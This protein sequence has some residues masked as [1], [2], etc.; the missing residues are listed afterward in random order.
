MSRLRVATTVAVVT[1]MFALG[2]AGTMSTAGAA[3]STKLTTAQM[4]QLVKAAENG[5]GVTPA[6]CHGRKYKIG[7]DIYPTTITFGQ[8]V[9]QGAKK[10]A[11]ESG[12]ITPIILQDNDV[13]E[14]VIANIHSFVEQK[15]SGIA[16][17][18]AVQGSEIEAISI[19]KAAKIPVVTA[20]LGEKG[21]PFIDVNDETAGEQEGSAVA[22]AFE[23]QIGSSTSPWIIEANYPLLPPASDRIS[24]WL[25]AVEKVFPNIPTNQ[26]I[27]FNSEL[28]V[29]DT[30]QAMGPV[31]A[32]IPS[33]A[34]ILTVGINDDVSFQAAEMAKAAGHPV[35]GSGFGGD[36]VGRTKVCT[37]YYDTDGWAPEKTMDYQYP[38]LIA[39]IFGHKFPNDVYQKT[40]LLTEQTV[41]HY[42]PGTCPAS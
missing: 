8:D 1:A 15:V 38:A 14:T 5:T 33:N 20:S 34:P 24:G 26:I 19:A 40:E 29:A 10:I 23:K 27:S 35:L 4:N 42:Y 2:A 11:K 25:S 21:T 7:I 3:S 41:N 39:M 32:T 9:V 36:H 16:I 28:N 17:L 18:S 6:M 22:A 12:C 13:A 37:G 31:L 30:A